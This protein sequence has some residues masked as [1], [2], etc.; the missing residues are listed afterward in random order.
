MGFPLQKG[1]Q[2]EVGD[3]TGKEVWKAR[4]EGK[5]VQ[6][7]HPPNSFFPPL[8]QIPLQTDEEKMRREKRRA[9]EKSEKT[10]YSEISGPKEASGS[11]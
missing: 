8:S 6:K 7:R 2:Q 9:A 10:I 5:E 11:S 1:F 3:S 4:G